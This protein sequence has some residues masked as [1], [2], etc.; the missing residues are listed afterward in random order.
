MWVSV[1]PR[2]KK[3]GSHDKMDRNQSP[4][5]HPCG[6][7]GALS[8]FFAQCPGCGGVFFLRPWSCS[9]WQPATS[10]VGPKTGTWKGPRREGQ[11][12]MEGWTAGT[13]EISPW[14]CIICVICALYIIHHVHYRVQKLAGDGSDVKAEYGALSDIMQHDITGARSPN[15][16]WMAFSLAEGPDSCRM[17]GCIYANT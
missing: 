5:S 11:G 10:A 15:S 4:G 6:L 14:E 13:F 3:T 9:T 7:T 16:E 17:S 12:A 2:H 1:S 8:S